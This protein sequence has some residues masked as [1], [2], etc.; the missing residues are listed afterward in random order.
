[1]GS[2]LEFTLCRQRCSCH[3]HCK[4]PTPP[5]IILPWRAI[6]TFSPFNQWDKM[7]A[8]VPTLIKKTKYISKWKITSVSDDLPQLIPA[9]M[10]WKRSHWS[11]HSIFGREVPKNDTNFYLDKKYRN[12][13]ILSIFTW[14]YRKS[15]M[16]G[17]KKHILYEHIWTKSIIVALWTPA[18]CERRKWPFQLNMYIPNSSIKLYKWCNCLCT[19]FSGCSVYD[20]YSNC[21]KCYP[22]YT[23]LMAAAAKHYLAVLILKKT[24]SYGMFRLQLSYIPLL[25][26]RERG[27]I[28]KRSVS[29]PATAL[30]AEVAWP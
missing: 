7:F 23:E 10:V 13:S 16:K 9:Q 27:S 8:C 26:E 20:K 30:E 15:M 18:F 29:L 21:R 11:S 22:A 24:H 12:L 28:I 3:E 19:G 4:K 1:M 2:L 5:E 25:K 14:I 6:L 17:I